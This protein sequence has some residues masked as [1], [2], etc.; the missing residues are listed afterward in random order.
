M[1]F[2][3]ASSSH[4]GVLRKCGPPK[5]ATQ[6]VDSPAKHSAVIALRRLPHPE[7][8]GGVVVED[9]PVS[10]PVKHLSHPERDGDGRR[11]NI[12]AVRRLALDMPEL[13]EEVVAFI[14]RRTA[15]E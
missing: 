12:P 2:D 10:E 1:A 15:P 11:F 13:M 9:Q 7:R 4:Y 5:R 6:E 14:E 3:R 8:D